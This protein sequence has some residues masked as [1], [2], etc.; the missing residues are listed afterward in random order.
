MK[1]ISIIIPMFNEAEHIQRTIKSAQ[2]AATAANLDCQIITVDNNSSD[3][4]AVLAE[5][6]GATV[7][8]KPDVKIGA[9][10]NAGAALADGDYLAFLDADIE[11]PPNWLSACLA[12]QHKQFDVIALDCDTPAQAPWFARAWQKRSMSKSGNNR[13]LDWLATPNLFLTRQRF[14]SSTGFNPLLSSGEDKEF[15]LRL[16]QQGAQ[17]VSLAQP[18]A[19]HW[20]YEKTWSEWLKKEFWRQSSHLQLFKKKPSLRLLRFPLLCV[21]TTLFTA[22]F[23]FSGLNGFSISSL[24]LLLFS[25]LPALVLAVRQSNLLSDSSYTLQLW[26]LH[27]LRLHIGCAALLRAALKN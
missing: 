11:V 23:A 16:H 21:A 4:S 14:K 17:Q 8:V 22:A 7:I 25:V 15:G 24:T 19:L 26:L 18:L 5:Q 9:L 12:Q 6:L 1:K 27:W 13:V 10:R 20:G 2:L 3:H